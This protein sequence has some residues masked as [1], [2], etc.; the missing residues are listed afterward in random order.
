MLRCWGPV[1]MTG[2][3]YAQPKSSWLMMQMSETHP[4]RRRV[5][6]VFGSSWG[7]NEVTPLCTLHLR[8]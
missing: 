1:L 3:S 7:D 5:R 8:A 6:S 2:E 4:E